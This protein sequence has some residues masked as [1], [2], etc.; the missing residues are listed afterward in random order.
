MQKI[1]YMQRTAY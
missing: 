1:E